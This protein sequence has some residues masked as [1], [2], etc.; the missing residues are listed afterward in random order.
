MTIWLTTPFWNWTMASTERPG[1]VPASRT[2]DGLATPEAAWLE[3]VV[4]LIRLKAET[5]ARS[6]RDATIATAAPA[7][8]PQR[9]RQGRAKG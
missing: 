3:A 5:A 1:W 4:L 2:S 8:N 9:I 7:E 6:T